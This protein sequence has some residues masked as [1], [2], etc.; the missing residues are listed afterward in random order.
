MS[1]RKH[2]LISVIPS[3]TRNANSL[4]RT[5]EG[6]ATSAPSFPSRNSCS[7]DGVRTMATCCHL[8]AVKMIGLL[9]THASP[10]IPNDAVNWLV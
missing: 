8:P 10:P 6:E 4:D 7:F 2:R 5:A 9:M 3:P 1:P